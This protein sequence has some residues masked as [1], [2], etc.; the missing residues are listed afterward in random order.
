MI[1]DSNESHSAGKRESSKVR[2]LNTDEGNLYVE[3][4][5]RLRR[6]RREKDYTQ[7]QMA[8]MLGISTAYYGKI[9][10]GVNSLSIKRLHT[11]NVKLGIDITYLITGKDNNTLSMGQ[12]LAECPIRKRHD[13]EQ[14]I[15][16]ALNLMENT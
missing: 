4:G 16:H 7:E 2:E 11:L 10:R 5:L 9:E 8:E 1:Q 13:L 6:I 3:I 14:I 15:K 12:I